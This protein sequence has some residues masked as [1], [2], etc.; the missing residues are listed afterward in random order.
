MCYETNYKN[1][2]TQYKITENASVYQTPLI[3][4]QGE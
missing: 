1:Q 3:F 4:K 2:S